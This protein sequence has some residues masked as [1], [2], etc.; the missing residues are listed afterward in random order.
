MNARE[1][2]ARSAP[3]K[4]CMVTCS[5][6]AVVRGAFNPSFPSAFSNTARKKVRTFRC[7][8]LALCFGSGWDDGWERI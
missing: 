7:E 3:S 2:K 4:I 6:R 1:A 8:P 5:S